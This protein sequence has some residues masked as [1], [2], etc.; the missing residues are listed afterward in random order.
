MRM[1]KLKLKKT[2]LG[3]IPQE[4]EISSADSFLKINMGQSPPSE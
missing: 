3:E 4:W 1:Q 2:E